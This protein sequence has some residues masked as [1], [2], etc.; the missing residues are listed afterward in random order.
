MSTALARE[1]LQRAAVGQP[2]ALTLGIFDGVHRGHQALMARLIESAKRTDLAP[3]VVTLHP[4]PRQVITP[5]VQISYITS[6]E[7]RLDLLHGLG[8]P[9]VVPV[10]FTS[11]LAQ[12]D[13]A[14]FVGL[15]VEHLQMRHLVIGPDFA[16]GRCR[17]GDPE[18]LRALGRELRFT[19]E[20]IEL[21]EE[22]EG[23]IS[24]TDIRRAL[25]TGAIDQVNALLGRRFS[26]HGPVI[27]GVQRGR[28]IGFPTANIAVGADRALPAVGVYAT[29]ARVAGA[30]LPSVTN[31]GV[32]PTFNDDAALSI[33][34]HVF[35]FDGDLYKRDLRIEF[36]ARLRGERKFDGADALVAQMKR[37]SAAARA[38]LGV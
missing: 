29:I 21:L 8:L 7:D 26:L 1:E 5:A 36:A 11:E 15:L 12:T 6:L 28:T 9:C 24:S 37:D 19:V 2:T 4:H 16:L 38:V 32:R 3:G 33:E 17:G 22:A 35:D 30:P 27:Y 13:A 14:D 18:T 25:S 31:I 34:C 10:T 20:V 23:K